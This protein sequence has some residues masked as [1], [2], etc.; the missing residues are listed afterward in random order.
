MI[1]INMDMPSSC[2]D[3]KLKKE[4]KVANTNYTLIYSCIF[5]NVG[6]V[7]FNG[8]TP[9]NYNINERHPKCPLKEEKEE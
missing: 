1:R 3:C 8:C 2:A 4:L 6:P 5:D 9:N 7:I